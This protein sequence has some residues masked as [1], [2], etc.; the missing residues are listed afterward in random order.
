MS[1]HLLLLPLHRLST[2]VKTS[3]H[4]I[5]ATDLCNFDPQHE[6]VL[7]PN[8]LDTTFNDEHEFVSIEMRKFSVSPWKMQQFYPSFVACQQN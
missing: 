5:S 6:N 4:T 7:R 1:I 2:G 3:T 8:A